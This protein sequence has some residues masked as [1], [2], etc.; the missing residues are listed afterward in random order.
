MEKKQKQNQDKKQQKTKKQK[1]KIS[2]TKIMNAGSLLILYVPSFLRVFLNPKSIHS[3]IPG[4]LCSFKIVWEFT[5]VA[6]QQVRV[7]GISIKLISLD[8]RTLLADK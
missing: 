6:N 1:K 3:Q 2:T 4:R 8:K 5:K 7:N